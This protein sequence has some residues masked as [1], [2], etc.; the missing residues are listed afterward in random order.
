TDITI[1]VVNA[2][3]GEPMGKQN[4][5]L[6]LGKD[7]SAPLMKGIT[8]EGGRAVFH[9]S[10]SLPERFFASDSSYMRGLCSDINFVTSEV[11]DR[12]VVP[13]NHCDEKHR[14]REP[15]RPRPGEAV[16]FQR[17]PHRWEYLQ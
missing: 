14:I 9:L 7:D 13:K 17:R 5:S 11:L 12:G 6:F 4:I 15:I 3:T 2:E 10:G 1:R 8:D 16:I